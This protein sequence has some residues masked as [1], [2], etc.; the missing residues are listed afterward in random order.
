VDDYVAMNRDRVAVD[1]SP[2][3]EV[4]SSD[5][6]RAAARCSGM[7]L[8]SPDLEAVGLRGV[9]AAKEA[10]DDRDFGAQ[11]TIHRRCGTMGGI[12]GLL[13]RRGRS[14]NRRDQRPKGER[15]HGQLRARLEVAISRR[16]KT[17]A[18]EAT[19]KPPAASAIP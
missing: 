8:L 5:R 17:V 12:D 18:S 16:P 13:G 6:D 10:T 15:A 3:A 1:A 11:T 2:H 9:D 4:A 19:R 14:K 7:N